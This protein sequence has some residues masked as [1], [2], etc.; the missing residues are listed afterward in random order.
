MATDQD[1][2]DL[3]EAVAAKIMSKLGDDLKM[4]A[5]NGVGITV[6][7][8]TFEPG[9]IAYLSTA[10]RDDMLRSIKEWV[11]CMEAGLVTEPRGERAQS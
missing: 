8:F 9:G 10:N 4:L 7:A 11:E 5:D 6:F 1:N 3:V 2:R